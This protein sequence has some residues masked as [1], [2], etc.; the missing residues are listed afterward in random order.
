MPNKQ[1]FAHLLGSK[2]TAKETTWGWRHFQVINRREEGQWVFAE[3]VASCDPKVRFWI[4]AKQLKD[5]S[6][7]QSGWQTLAQMNQSEEDHEFDY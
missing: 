1:K 3:M 6:L 5:R 7:W 2:W 4:N